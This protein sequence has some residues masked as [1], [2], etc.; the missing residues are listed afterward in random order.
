M[1]GE[2]WISWIEDHVDIDLHL[3][4]I[5]RQEIID[6][7]TYRKMRGEKWKR[8]ERGS[9]GESERARERGRRGEGGREE[10][11][12]EGGTYSRAELGEDSGESGRLSDGH[13]LCAFSAHFHN[14]HR[15]PRD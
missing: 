3:F 4:F 5:L 11:R 8:M 14:Q 2:G 7:R 12:K 13:L 15:R 1:N 9:E 10:G 6:T